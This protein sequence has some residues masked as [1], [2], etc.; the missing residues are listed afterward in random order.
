MKDATIDGKLTM[1]SFKKE[2]EEDKKPSY[3]K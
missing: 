3:Y 2:G 1:E